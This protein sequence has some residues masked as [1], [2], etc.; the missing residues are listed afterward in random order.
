MKKNWHKISLAFFLCI[1]LIGTL[2]RA[3]PF[4][5]LPANYIFLLHAHSHLA[6]Q[7]WIYTMILLLVPTLFLSPDQILKGRYLLQFKLTV[8]LLIGILVSF[9]F[10]GYSIL[11]IILSTLFQIL[12]YWFIFRFFKDG[13]RSKSNGISISF[14]RTG[15]WFSLLSSIAPY[16]VGLL[17]AKK[18]QDSEFYEAAIYFFLHFQYNGWFIFTVL[19]IAIK[20]L[21]TKNIQISSHRMNLFLK[22]MTVS[23]VLLYCHSLLGMSFGFSVII[24]SLLGASLQ[25][26]AAF[27]LAKAIRGLIVKKSG[28]VQIVIYLAL[29]GFFLKVILQLF[30][31]IPSFLPVI[32][33]NRSLIMAYMHLSLIGIISF[34]FLAF[35]LILEWMKEAIVTR[36]GLFFLLS[37]YLLSE[38][39]LVWFG[40]GFHFAN[41]SLVIFSLM[42]ALGIFLMLINPNSKT[43][44]PKSLAD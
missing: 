2:L 35:L 23:T 14:I 38:L 15:F 34:S 9:S 33:E 29:L 13:S 10:W 4:I 40:L 25:L 5:D 1:A 21:E 36:V 19:G 16:F 28:W 11:S 37:G 17:S 32:F 22:L 30:S 42:M 39:Y 31:H 6:F 20:L 44:E 26:F 7:G 3:M 12:T 24:P 41:G 27:I 18:M 43:T 8:P